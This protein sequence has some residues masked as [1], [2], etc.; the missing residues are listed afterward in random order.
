MFLRVSNLVLIFLMLFIFSCNNKSRMGKGLTREEKEFV[1]R[2]QNELLIKTT[3]QTLDIKK[4]KVKSEEDIIPITSPAV[5]PVVY[6]RFLSTKHMIPEHKKSLFI[7]QLL[8]QILIAKFFLQQEKEMLDIILHD[9]NIEKLNFK[10]QKAFI[11]KQMLKHDAENSTDLLQKLTTHPTSIILAQAAIESNWGSSLSF[12]QAN[13]PFHIRAANKEQPSL[14][15]FGRNEEVVYLK[16][17]EYLPAA[18]ADYFRNINTHERFKE[19]RSMR[20]KTDDPMALVP[21]LEKYPLLDTGD[22]EEVLS[23]FIERNNL[24]KYDNYFLDSEYINQMTDD[25]IAEIV[26]EQTHRSKRVVTSD[27]ERIENITERSVEIIYED[28]EKPEDIKPVESK[29]IAPYVHTNALDLKYLPI[30]E[31]KEKFF[32]MLL[33]SVMVAAFGINETKKKL[34]V[35]AQRIENGEAISRD[36]SLF[37]EK[38]LNDWKARD[39]ENLLNVKMVTHPNSIML[40]QAALETGWGSSRFFVH[41]NNTFGVWSFNSN[42]SRIRARETRSGKPVYVRKY[43]NLS[44]SII[45]YYKV[46][47]RGPYSEY[48]EQRVESE[49]PYEMVDYLFRYSEIGQEYTQ[50]LK[51]VMRNANLEKYDEYRIDP[52]YINEEE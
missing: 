11:E 49:D 42:E 29:F 14:K 12:E 41:A 34:Q 25:E 51:T 38:Q 50:R 9:E 26:T 48:R 3:N 30:D 47:A 37:L 36:D 39:V 31:K 23:G 17:Y 1:S 16:E 18:I 24:T 13:N 8:P 10:D 46:I 43:D 19:F 15:T 4:I 32:D 28:L 27:S 33:P 6:S 5:R 21:Y 45:D 2:F 20:I 7:S 40:A 44:Q 22:Y 52:K 35:I